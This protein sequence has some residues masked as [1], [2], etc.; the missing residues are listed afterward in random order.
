MNWRILALVAFGGAVGSVLRYLV[1]SR[2]EPHIAGTL[3]VNALGCF[4]IGILLF[5]GLQGGWLTP[6]ARALLAVG[7]LGG[8]TTMSSFSYET[9]ALFEAQQ[10]NLGVSNIVL[11]LA[12]CLL[13]TWAGRGLGVAVWPAS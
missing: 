6:E 3:A 13:G 5:G 10:V 1:A 8:F 9:V 4:L 11:T 12:S 7:V 2:I